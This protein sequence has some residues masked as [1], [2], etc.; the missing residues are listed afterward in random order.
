MAGGTPRA[1]VGTGPGTPKAPLIGFGRWIGGLG[2][3]AMW[4]IE[5]HGLTNVPATGPVVLAANHLAGID[6]PL[7]AAYSPRPAHLLVKKELM[8][9]LLGWLL[10]K[11]GQI[12]VDRTN[13]REALNVGLSILNDGGVV[14]LF[15]EGNRGRG[16][17]SEIRAG[18]AW[19]AVHGSAQVVPVAC[20]GT[21]ATGRG[22]SSMP[23][24]RSRIVIA[25]GEPLSV[26]REPEMSTRDAVG[27]MSIRIQAALAGHVADSASRFGIALPDDDAKRQGE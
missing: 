11:C 15:P 7:L 2:M 9:G 23:G 22:K 18:A 13:G 5:L 16:A 19:L 17:V 14:G 10:R 20:L 12:E 8:R 25:F 27:Q 1:R 26:E 3:R 24:W 21:R 6:G 4:K